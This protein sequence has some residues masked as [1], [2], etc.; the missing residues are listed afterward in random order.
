MRWRASSHRLTLRSFLLIIRFIVLSLLLLCNNTTFASLRHHYCCYHSVIIASQ[1][2]LK[3][4]IVFI[5]P[6]HQLWRCH[7]EQRVKCSGASTVQ[8]ILQWKLH[9]RCSFNNFTIPLQWAIPNTATT[10]FLLWL[11]ITIVLLVGTYII[12]SLACCAAVVAVAA[13]KPNSDP[14]QPVFFFVCPP[15]W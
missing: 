9:T 2:W 13:D 1:W 6:C 12:S 10:V 15:F 5:S 3:N 14:N 8:H 4:N 11:P 7:G